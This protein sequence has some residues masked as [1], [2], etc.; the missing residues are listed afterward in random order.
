MLPSRFSEKTYIENDFY[1]C[2]TLSEAWRRNAAQCPDKVAISDS[3]TRLTWAEACRWIDRLALALIERNYSKSDVLLVQL[4]N[5]VELALIRLACERAGCMCLPLN[6]AFREKEM[7]YSARTVR[8][9]GLLIPEQLGKFN[10]HAMAVTLC[11][12][13]DSLEDIFMVGDTVADGVISF[14]ALIRDPIEK[15]YPQDTLDRTQCSP[16]EFSTISTTTGTTGFPKFVERAIFTYWHTAKG[17]GKIW[18]ITPD[19]VIGIF[20]PSASGPNIAGYH[21]APYMQCRV[22]ML[23]KFNSK[24]ALDIIEKEKI[25]VIPLVPTMLVKMMQDPDFER[26]DLSSLRLIV[27]MGAVLPL[28]LARK[29]EAKTKARVVQRYGSVDSGLSSTHSPK[30][31]FEIRTTTVGKPIGDGE[32]KLLDDNG[33][34]VDFG[35]TGEVVVRVKREFGGYFMDPQAT[36]NTWNTDGW[37]HMGDLG[38]WHDDGHLKIVGRKKEMI[39]RGGQNIYPAEIEN[40]LLAHAKIKEVAIVPVPDSVMGEKACACVVP[41]T[42]TPPITLEEMTA[43]L[44]SKN[45]SAYKLPE[46]LVF[47]DELPLAGQQKIDKKS[48]AHRVRD[49]MRSEGAI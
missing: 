20:S 5:R 13:M 28:D 1:G 39:I 26:F 12:E 30:W 21:V 27:C 11:R 46:H 49:E 24:D 17:F 32:V 19:D 4:P 42:H 47:M 8:A 33:N 15:R 36:L 23:E 22:A 25:T 41:D 35:E 45:L 2:M 14:N 38:Q 44:K 9:K 34:P 37:F 31:P 18:E 7:M 3:K 43:Y 6:P 48:L 29:V 10:T 40:L 16:M